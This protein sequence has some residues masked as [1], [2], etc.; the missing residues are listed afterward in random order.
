MPDESKPASSGSLFNFSLSDIF[1]AGKGIEKL[2]ATVGGGAGRVADGIGE[3]AQVKWLDRAKADNE[4]YRIQ[5]VG[6]AQTRVMESRARII[7]DMAREGM[8]LQG[9]SIT[10]AEISAQLTGLSPELQQLHQRTQQRIAYE[11]IMEQLN[12]DTVVAHAAAELVDDE[13]IAD[14]PV[15]PDWMK[16]VFRTVQDISNEEMQLIFGKILA[17][18]VKQP[19]SF[20]LRTVDFLS[21]F[22][23]KE[24]ASFRD[25][26]AFSWKDEDDID[27]ILFSLEENNWNIKMPSYN[28]LQHLAEIGLIEYS[29]GMFAPK[30]GYEQST[31]TLSYNGSKFKIEAET[32]KDDTGKPRISAGIVLLTKMGKELAQ[33]CQ[34]DRDP[35]IME[36]TIDY[37]TKGRH[38]V[39]PLGP[40][41]EPL[42][43]QQL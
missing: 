18:E 13:Q 20:S 28:E 2:A 40:I 35:C 33:V 8:N 14:E 29:V 31:I 9:L 4:A 10:N 34:P 42:D 36:Y 37:W 38:K 19:G 39:T 43:S 11:N 7:S 27:I 26:C 16:R 3:V 25:I 32:P 15:D 30:F 22:T 21:T 1:G 17:G 23:K 12:R 24:A 5:A 6:D 41:Q